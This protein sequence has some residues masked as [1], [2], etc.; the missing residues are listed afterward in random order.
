MEKIK[1]MLYMD[2]DMVVKFRKLAAERQETGSRT[3]T[4]QKCIVDC[5]QTFWDTLEAE[6]QKDDGS[7]EI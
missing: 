3:Y 5:L 2:Y 6:R 4:Y 1:V 7:A